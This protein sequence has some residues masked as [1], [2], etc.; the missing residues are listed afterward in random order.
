VAETSEIDPWDEPAAG[1]DDEPAARAYAT[2]AFDS[3]VAALEARHLDLAGTTVCDFGCGTG[4]LTELM[5]DTVGSI[6][7]VDTSTVMLE[8]LDAKIATTGWT[9]V[10]TS[11]VPP[12]SSGQHDL[13]VCSSVC[14]FLDDYPG[15]V[16]QLA[17]LLKA[18]GVF[19]QWD[20]ERPNADT[21]SGGLSRQEIER[22][23]S[24]AALGDVHVDTAFR[25]EI[26]G[27]VMQP[28]IGIGQKPNPSDSGDAV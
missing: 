16:R 11:A 22:A 27:H 4:L 25:V 5:A 7:A 17:R 10:Q 19:V 26:D 6:E 24:S 21:D 18:G 13:V 9:N 15:T 23:I 1:W 8:V 28:L 2:A 14:S 12:V 20:W 3:L